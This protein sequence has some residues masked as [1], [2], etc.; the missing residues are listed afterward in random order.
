[1]ARRIAKPVA[2]TAAVTMPAAVS[3]IPPTHR[4]SRASERAISA[5]NSARP[6]FE[7]LGRDVVAL[8]D[9]LLHDVRNGGGLVGLQTGADQRRFALDD[10]QHQVLRFRP[11]SFQ[12]V[13]PSRVL[14]CLY[15][16]AVR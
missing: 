11:S 1:M 13:F 2:T 15:P 12:A 14:N 4:I 16:S 8:L 5:H 9:G 7:L 3:M 6:V 10:V